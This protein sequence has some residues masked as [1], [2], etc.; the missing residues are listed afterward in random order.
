[1][2]VPITVAPSLSNRTV[3]SLCDGFTY[4]SCRSNLTTIIVY[5]QELS[6]SLQVKFLSLLTVGVVKGYKGTVPDGIKGIV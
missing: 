2:F 1:M 4:T 3:K 6:L 5:K